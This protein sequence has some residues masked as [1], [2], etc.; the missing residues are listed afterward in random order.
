MIIQSDRLVKNPIIS[1]AVT[2]YNHETYLRDCLDNIL[3]QKISV[4]I[5]IIIAEDCS[6]D[7]TRAICKEYQ[8]RYPHLI[9]LLLQEEN[10]GLLR[11]F[12]DLLGLCRGPYIAEC[13][14]DDYWCDDTKL[15]K[16][17]DFL[18]SHPDYGVVHTKG[19]ELRNGKLC[20]TNGGHIAVEGDAREIAV[21]GPIGIASSI[22]F[23]RELLAY[24]D[25]DDIIR[26]EISMEDYPMNAIFAHH[27]YFT[28][29]KEKMV[30]YRVLNGSIS[31][32][33]AVKYVV[34]YQ[35]ARRLIKDMYPD[36]VPWTYEDIND[37]EDY[38]RLKDCYFRFDW[39]GAKQLCFNTAGYRNRVLVRYRANYL[40][41]IILSIILHFKRSIQSN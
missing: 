16:Q 11:N 19:Y 18:A 37:A 3:S 27:T 29:L 39:R 24:I 8:E 20:D 14:G 12:K 40:V 30:V 2:T 35:E 7:A 9:V 22:F 10:R 38:A 17:Y 28:T 31:H 33:R 4:P 41:F 15:Q 32:A 13:S 1:V 5:E 36:E 6:T 21:Y 34:G 23:R 26:R 25:M